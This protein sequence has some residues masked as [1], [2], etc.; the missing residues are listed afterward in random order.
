ME[1]ESG[2]YV[3]IK[4]EELELMLRVGLLPEEREGPQRVLVSMDLYADP[5]YLDGVD[6]DSIIDYGAICDA[7]TRWQ[8]RPHVELLETLVQ[9]ALELGFGYEAV[10]AV[11]VKVGKPEIVPSAR[12]VLVESF[13]KRI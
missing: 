6:A 5:S 3:C 2:N 13:C 12:N 7:L 4:I 8:D 10:Q 1:K 9:D 11:R